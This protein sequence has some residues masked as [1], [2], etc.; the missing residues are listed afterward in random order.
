MK[1]L[2]SL[3]LAAHKGGFALWKL[4]FVL[5]FGIPFNRPHR[6]KIASLSSDTATCVVPYRRSNH[7]HIR[8]THACALATCAEFST[9]LLLLQYLN[10]ASY[11]IIMKTMTMEYHYQAKADVR[12][13]FQMTQQEFEERVLKPLQENDTVDLACVAHLRD[14]SGNHIATGTTVWQI[15]PWSRVRTKV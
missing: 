12:S 4:N 2:H 14:T 7:N 5:S 11:R 3:M 1:K 8:G 6:I 9:G 10:P 13:V 15:K